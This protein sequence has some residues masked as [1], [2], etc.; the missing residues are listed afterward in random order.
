LRALRSVVENEQLWAALMAALRE[1]INRKSGL[2]YATMLSYRDSNSVPAS[3]GPYDTCFQNCKGNFE[4]GTTSRF[5]CIR[6][7]PM[8]E[9]FSD[10]MDLTAPESA[11]T[12]SAFQKFQH[13]LRDSQQLRYSMTIER[14][15]FDGDPLPDVPPLLVLE[16]SAEAMV[17]AIA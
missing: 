16:A 3:G 11:E 7:C 13:L 12:I 4:I 1:P 10:P 6:G 2:A 5:D 17:G 15:S 14:A 8:G 9:I